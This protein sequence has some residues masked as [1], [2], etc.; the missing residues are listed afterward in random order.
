MM[1]FSPRI[2]LKPQIAYSRHVF[3][4]L[5]TV[6]L[7]VSMYTTLHVLIVYTV[8]SIHLLYVYKS[9]SRSVLGECS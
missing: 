9:S 2:H 8:G 4:A 1:T 7:K 3:S 5:Y 6:C